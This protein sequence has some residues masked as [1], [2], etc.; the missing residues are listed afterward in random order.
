MLEFLEIQRTV[1]ERGGHAETVVHQRLLARTVA[2]IHPVELRDGL[3][4]FI[5]KEQ[6]I[7]R[8]I[9]QQRGGRFA[10]QAAGEMP[11]IVLDA[12]AI[13]DRAH[14]LD[15]EH[16]ALPHAL[17]LRVFALLF[18]FGLPP[19]EL[20][21]NRADGALFLRG[22]HDVMRLRI[23][24]Q[25]RQIV[26]AGAN[27]PGQRV[28]LADGVHLSAPEFDCVSVVLI[29]R[30]NFQ[31][32]AA[33]AE[34]AAAQILGALVL[35]V[36]QLAQQCLARRALPL[37][38]HQEHAVIRFRGTEAVNAGDR[39]DDDDVPAFEQRAGRAHAQLVEFVVDRGFLLDIR[40]RGGKIR[41][42]LVVIVIA[43]KVFDGV[44]GKE[45]LEFAVELRRERLV[46]REHQHRTVRPLDELG[47]RERLSGTG[48]AEQDLMLLARLDAARE[49][50][51]GLRLIAARLVIAHEFEVHR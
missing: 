42:R 43:D 23:D 20:F 6:V 9:V 45:T 38:D 28:H 19:V 24:R 13:S 8:E 29:R 41:F 48:D 30:I 40:V 5:D 18:K 25:S 22:G 37:L 46:M 36:H 44:L 14:H 2:V 4:R 34:R 7:L 15:V 47:R 31:A 16:R 26:L 49:L 1:V 11:R 12:V 21:Q 32:I 33:H 3:V 51:D 39:S 27:F 35:D 50:L 10:G 17:R